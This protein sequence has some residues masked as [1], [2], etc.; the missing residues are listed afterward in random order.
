[1][2][3][4]MFKRYHKRR[5]EAIKLLGGKCVKCESTKDLQFDHIDPTTKS[6]T[7]AKQSSIAEYKFWL[8]IKKCQLLCQECHTKKTL[9][10]LNRVSAKTTHGTLS[11]YRYCKCNLCKA[12]NNLKSRIYK[13]K[14]KLASCA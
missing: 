11:S 1:M 8:E 7:I 3:E 5:L 13:N 2:K 12:A 9:N 6:F 14:R 10:D 4:Y